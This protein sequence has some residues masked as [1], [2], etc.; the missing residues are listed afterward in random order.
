MA[1]VYVGL[2]TN[3]GDREN[4]LRTAVRYMEEK[5]G[6]TLSLSSFYET[7]P[8]GFTSGYRFLNAA[9]C[10]ETALQPLE[11]LH[12][13][14]DIERTMGRIQKSEGGIYHDRIIDIDLLLYDDIILHT[15]ELTLPHPLMT[16][17]DF[18]MIPLAEITGTTSLPCLADYH[19]K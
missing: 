8:W 19:S 14:Q 16:V 12:V 11:V 6:K 10:I 15:P 13:T 2:G 4:N 17:R 1:K 7:E 9:A 3:L 5:V 18:V